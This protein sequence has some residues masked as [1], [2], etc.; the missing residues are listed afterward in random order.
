MQVHEKEFCNIANR[1]LPYAYRWRKLK[2]LSIIII[3]ID[4]FLY[5]PQFTLTAGVL[6]RIQDML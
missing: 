6:L 4:L 2:D 1:A 5:F 3:I